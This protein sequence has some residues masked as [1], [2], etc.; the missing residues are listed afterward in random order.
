M[1]MEETYKIKDRMKNHIKVLFEQG[2]NTRLWLGNW[3]PKGVLKKQYGKRIIYDI[4][5]DR[6]SKLNFILTNEV[7]HPPPATFADLMEAWSYLPSLE[8]L[9]TTNKD[10]M[11]WTVTPTGIFTMSSAWRLTREIVPQ[12]DW[13]K[14]VWSLCYIPKHSLLAWRVMLKR[15]PTQSRLCK[16]RIL[17]S[18]QCI[19]CWNNN[20]YLDNLF[21][22]CMFTSSIWE[23]ILQLINSHRKRARNYDAES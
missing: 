7:W 11:V 5:M 20:E 15:L 10:I 6:L 18:S 13:H 22:G 2:S 19:F 12:V 17:T 21:F 23:R 8:R 4:G 3:H 16:M 9:N 14:V 1:V